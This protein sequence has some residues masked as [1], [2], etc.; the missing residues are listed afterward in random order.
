MNYR[1]TDYAIRSHFVIQN[2]SLVCFSTSSEFPVNKKQGDF[3]SSISSGYFLLCLLVLKFVFQ[4][5]TSQH[6]LQFMWNIRKWRKVFNL[7]ETFSSTW[8]REA[9]YKMEPGW[10]ITSSCYTAFNKM[11]ISIQSSFYLSTVDGSY[12]FLVCLIKW[13]Y[14][15]HSEIKGYWPPH[16]ISSLVQLL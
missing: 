15:L 6:K 5:I 2:V 1:L 4:F 16:A 11:I 13:H 9:D 14:Q 10:L 12:T 3:N 7:K 8:V